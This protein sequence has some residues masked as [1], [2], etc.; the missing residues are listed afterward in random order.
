MKEK[1]YLSYFLK[2]QIVENNTLVISPTG[3][4]KTHYIFNDCIKEGRYL[5]LCDNENLK[6]AIES[7]KRT[8]SNRKLIT[9]FDNYSVE[10]MC[11]KEFGSKVLYDNNLIKEYHAIICDEIHNLVD[12]QSFN[13]DTDLSHAI[14]ELFKKYDETKII[15]FT[16]TPF[17]LKEL[18]KKHPALSEILNI[19]DFSERKDIRRYINRREAYINHLS[20][21]QFQLDEYKQSFE[22]GNMKCL[23][24]TREIRA[25]KELEQ[26]CKSKNL[27]P[28]CIWSRNNLITEMNPEQLR[29]RDYLL[30]N[31][32][33][34]E[35]YNVLII[36][37]A[38]ETGINIIDKD[39]NLA[40]VN[41]TNLTQQIQ[42]RGRI[43][44]DIDLLVVRTKEQK[45]PALKLKIDEKYLDIELTKDEMKEIIIELNLK[46]K[47]NQYITVNKFR[48]LLESNGY[49]VRAPRKTENNVKT[50]Y[51]IISE[52]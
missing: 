47:K 25:M 35:P 24:F 37:R 51:Y 11:Y 19:I 31:G 8:F 36:N 39:M 20:Q 2:D 27:N 3:S 38:L 6:T 40:I 33:L 52:S 50:T 32:E 1:Q 46:N 21:V 26:M 18:E 44:H 16:A 34:P 12:Y 48:Q 42:V 7:E 22:Y 15:Y 30:K 5:Y 13:N 41:T 28:I 29:V 23:I 14:K 43:R 49:Q 10:V 17:Y 4:G 9:G 45:L